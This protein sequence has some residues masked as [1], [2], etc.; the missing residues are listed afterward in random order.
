[1]KLGRIAAQ[2]L[3]HPFTSLPSEVWVHPF[4]P[5]AS[6]TNCQGCASAPP[7]SRCLLWGLWRLITYQPFSTPPPAPLLSTER[8]EHE[9]ALFNFR[10]LHVF[11]FS[12]SWFNCVNVAEISSKESRMVLQHGRKPEYLQQLWTL[13]GYSSILI[14]RINFT[15]TST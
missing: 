3:V 15:I 4:T 10:F 12:L 6:P 2:V 11:F 13:T 5:V 8:Q 9:T 7:S 14:F 1:M